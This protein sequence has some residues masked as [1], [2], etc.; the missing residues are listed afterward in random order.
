[1]F[2][3][4]LA[5]VAALT[6]LIGG[7]AVAATPEATYNLQISGFV[8][9][10]CDAQLSASAVPAQAGAVSLGK[11]S[12]FCNDANGYQV[13]VDYSPS[14]AGDTMQVGSRTIMLT[15][16]GSALIDESAVPVTVSKAASLI[17]S[18][19]GVSGEISIR[20]VAL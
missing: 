5:G 19:G 16:S 17:V 12:E 20:V 1:M 8:P 3:K 7:A 14:L 10:I 9:V 4:A 15:S 6:F 2:G 18:Q 13:W 11:I